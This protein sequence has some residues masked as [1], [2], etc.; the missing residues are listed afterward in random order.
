MLKV[1]S[2]YPG[3]ERQP[4]TAVTRNRWI[5]NTRKYFFLSSCKLSGEN[6]EANPRLRVAA[7]RWQQY[8]KPKQIEQY[9]SENLKSKALAIIH[10][11]FWRTNVIL[12]YND[13]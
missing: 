4:I 7:S 1:V 10:I 9:D 6:P 5:G 2:N 11:N 8:W 13:G 12:H 3:K